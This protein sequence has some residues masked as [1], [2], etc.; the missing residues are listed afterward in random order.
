MDW[1]G[2][3]R[4]AAGDSARITV[5][6]QPEGRCR[7]PLERCWPEFRSS[8]DLSRCSTEYSFGGP[9]ILAG[10]QALHR[11]STRICMATLSWTIMSRSRDGDMARFDRAVRKYG[12]GWTMLPPK[13]QA[14]RMHSHASPK[15]RRVLSARQGRSQFTCRRCRERGIAN[16]PRRAKNTQHAMSNLPRSLRM[17]AGDRSEFARKRQMP[18]DERKFLGSDFENRGERVTICPDRDNSAHY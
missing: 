8:S 10:D 5:P 9:L 12:I 14:N 7:Q 17:K 3:G 13:S 15:W 2:C 11:R 6:L 4:R 16:L 1:C 18:A